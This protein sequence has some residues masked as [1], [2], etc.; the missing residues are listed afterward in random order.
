MDASVPTII[1]FASIFTPTPSH[2]P[3]S[4]VL[5]VFHPPQITVELLNT[6]SVSAILI[7]VPP[8]ILTVLAFVTM[9]ISAISIRELCPTIKLPPLS[10]VIASNVVVKL[11][12][13][14]NS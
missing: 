11:S 3:N 8:P 6:A 7:I 4:F 10:T 9:N 2:S 14:T 5:L 1:L 12:S 13:N